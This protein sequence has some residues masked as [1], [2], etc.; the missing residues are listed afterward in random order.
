MIEPDIPERV[1]VLLISYELNWLLREPLFRN[2][3][4]QKSTCTI[5]FYKEGENLIF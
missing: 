3:K 5:A 2:K 4:F 1:K